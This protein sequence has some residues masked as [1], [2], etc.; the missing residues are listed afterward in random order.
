MSQ[1]QMKEDI[2]MNS[3]SQLEIDIP[4]KGR[5]C[6]DTL[7]GYLHTPDIHQR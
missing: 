4:D 6:F 2:H 5:D 3:I 1:E 7:F